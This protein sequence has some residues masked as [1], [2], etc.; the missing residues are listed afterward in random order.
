M[1]SKDDS[2]IL[3]NDTAYD[4]SYDTD[5]N[6]YDVYYD[7]YYDVHEKMNFDDGDPRMDPLRARMDPGLMG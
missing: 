1:D 6:V 7:V 3:H 2:L 4:N 5:N